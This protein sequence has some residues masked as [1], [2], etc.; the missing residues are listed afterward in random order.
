MVV[1]RVTL[2]DRAQALDVHRPVHDVLVHRPLEQ[3]GEEE[4]D[5]HGEPFERGHVVD[6]LDVDV[7]RRRAHG[8]DDRDVK[9]TVVPSHDARPVLLP[10][11]DLALADHGR[12]S[13][14]R[15]GRGDLGGCLI[16]HTSITPGSPV[17]P[18]SPRPAAGGVPPIMRATAGSCAAASGLP[19]KMTSPR[20]ITYSL[21]A[22]S[23]R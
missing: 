2:I 9:V 6:V 22:K 12:S 20:S 4:G 8:V 10:E 19:A 5:R 16:Y 21:S 18:D 23:G 14:R 15:R 11:I 17:Q 1:E 3:V 13:S 7:E